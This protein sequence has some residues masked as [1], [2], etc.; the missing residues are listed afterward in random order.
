MLTDAE[1]KKNKS[2]CYWIIFKK[3]KISFVFI[4][5]SYFKVPKAIR[6]NAIHYFIK[7]IPD[8]KA[9][10]QMVSNHSADTDFKQF[11]KL[12]IKI[13]QK[14]HIHCNEWYDCVIR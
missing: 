13:I 12:C 1:N 4:S 5:Q 2:Y 6:L 10:P 8:K 11:M 14:S 3:K 7:K 9:L